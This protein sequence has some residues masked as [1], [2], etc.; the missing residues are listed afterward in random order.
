MS[1]E[2]SGDWVLANTKLDKSPNVDHL[3]GTVHVNNHNGANITGEFR[4]QAGMPVP[5]IG[6]KC[7]PISGQRRS[8]SFH[9]EFGGETLAFRG[10][11]ESGSNTIT[12]GTF[13]IVIGPP[14]PGDTGTW[15]ATRGGVNLGGGKGGAQKRGAAAK[16]GKG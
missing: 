9:I 6:G 5:L 8:L 10:T 13:V 15:E 4:P 12:C 11:I 14:D 1:N 7:H 2:C 3:M 16:K